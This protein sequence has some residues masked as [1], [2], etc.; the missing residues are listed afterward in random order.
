MPG[1]PSSDKTY[2]PVREIYHKSNNEQH[3]RI[4]KEKRKNEKER[5]N[6]RKKEREG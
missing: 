4:L 6:E 1:E 3:V 5:K 2:L